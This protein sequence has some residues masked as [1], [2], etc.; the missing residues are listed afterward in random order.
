[1][2]DLFVHSVCLD[3]GTDHFNP[4]IPIDSEAEQFLRVNIEA[5]KDDLPKWIA[6]VMRVAKRNKVTP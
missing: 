4:Q 2:K 1:M 3:L 5:Y 6:H